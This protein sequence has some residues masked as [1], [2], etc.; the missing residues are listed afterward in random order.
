MFANTKLIE[1]MPPESADDFYENPPPPYILHDRE[2]TLLEFY[3]HL[4]TLFEFR[5]CGAAHHF[6]WVSDQNPEKCPWMRVNP[7]CSHGDTR[8]AAEFNWVMS[9]VTALNDRLDQTLVSPQELEQIDRLFFDQYV[10][11]P[12]SPRLGIYLHEA[13][14][15]REQ[16]DAPRV[17]SPELAQEV[18]RVKNWQADKSEF[19][20]ILC[21]FL[22][23]RIQETLLIPD[24]LQA[25]PPAKQTEPPL[26]AENIVVPELTE[27]EFPG[28]M[29]RQYQI[30]VALE[31]T[32]IRA[33]FARI[34]DAQLTYAEWV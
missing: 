19:F 8:V 4:Q 29:R 1:L 22:S 2:I 34:T 21:K 6:P 31:G 28:E 12:G 24:A 33:V 30:P 13:Q 20:F 16:P 10:M 14:K 3:Q 18:E 5:A 15:F 17:F 32:N 23:D 11:H 9:V 26:E 7:G 27:A 25:L